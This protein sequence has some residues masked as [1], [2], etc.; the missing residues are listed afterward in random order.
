M[1]TDPAGPAPFSFHVHQLACL[2]EVE[3]S[4]TFTEAARRLHVSQPALSQSLAELERRA[5]VALFE[6]AGRLRVLTAAGR[7]VARFAAEV[8]GR[9]E[10]L[11]A[12][13]AEYGEGGSGPLSVGMIDAASL[14]ALPDAI[15]GFRRSH[16][17]V[18]LRLVVDTSTVLIERLRRFELDL[19]FIVG[20][21][22]DDLD[23]REVARETLHIYAPPGAPGTAAGAEWVLYPRGSQT[24]AIIDKGFGRMGLAPRV[25]LE[26]GNPEVLRQMVA[27]GLGWSVLPAAV[28]EVTPAMARSRREAVCERVLL[29]VR[30]AGAPPDPRAEAFLAL[31]SG[32]RT[33]GKPRG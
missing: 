31:A 21:A 11:H 19:A 29:G 8:L 33:G 5:G 13:L 32:G 17:G 1:N 15:R 7:E 28:A 6:P 20:P 10:E 27:L 4:G 2:R 9:A 12:W 26:S 23:G 14:Y 25:T 18:E 16:P 22:P 30:R 24:R 3:R